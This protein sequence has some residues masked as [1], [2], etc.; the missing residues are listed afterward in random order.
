[1]TAAH[2]WHGVSYG[3]EAP[4][5]VTVYVEIVPTDTTKYELDKES[6]LLKVDRVQKYSNVCP[7]IYGFIPRTYCAD[8]VAALASGVAGI[9][10]GDGDPLDICVLAERPVAQRNLLLDARPIGGIRLVDRDEAD[11]KIVSVLYQDPVYGELKDLSECPE[12]LLDRIRHYFLTYK[13]GPGSELQVCT[14][15]KIYG[16]AE[17]RSVI[18]ASFR[19]YQRYIHRAV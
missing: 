12:A 5:V 13:Q 10:K 19:D 1:M 14:I 2:P 11:D 3:D 15:E 6:G 16:A 9:R 18:E 7:T 17:A 4:D 8:E